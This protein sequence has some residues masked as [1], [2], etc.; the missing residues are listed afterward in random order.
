MW[1]LRLFQTKLGEN[2]YQCHNGHDPAYDI[3]NEVGFILRGL[4]RY[5]H[6]WRRSPCHH[7]RWGVVVLT[8]GLV[9]SGAFKRAA[10]PEATGAAAVQVAA[11]PAHE[12][13][14]PLAH[15]VVVATALVLHVWGLRDS[16][17]SLH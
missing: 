10:E 9:Q 6:F 1:T 14:I 12:R 5:V 3:N 16:N 8:G 13:R 2:P 11:R 15:H 4:E 17:L 7:P